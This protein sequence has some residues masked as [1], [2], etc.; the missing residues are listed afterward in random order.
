MPT[1]TSG[2]HTGTI[3]VTTTAAGDTGFDG[4][5][6]AYPTADAF[7]LKV[8]TANP[9]AFK[10]GDIIT[11]DDVYDVHPETKQRYGYLK[12]FVVQED[13]SNS[14]GGTLTV[15]ILPFPILSGAYQNVSGPIADSK[16]VTKLGGTAGVTYG[17][18]LLFH[19]DAYAF[20]TA[21]LEDPSQYGAWGAREVFEGVSLRIWRQG[22]ISN[23]NFPC[24]LDL[25]W[26]F[27]AIYPEWSVRWCHAQE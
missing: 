27:A 16:T 17:Q 9:M 20:V 21:D 22:D 14:G 10:A 11:I 19:R 5:G 7:D 1:H 12:R 15:P 8:D 24:R 25:A 18:N 4:T 2:A 23:G 6:N 3:T 13:K 26:G